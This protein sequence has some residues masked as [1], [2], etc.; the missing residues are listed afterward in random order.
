M[1]IGKVSNAIT[2]EE[3]AKVADLPTPPICYLEIPKLAVEPG[4][5]TEGEVYYNT[6][7][8]KFY[9]YENAAWVE[10]LFSMEKVTP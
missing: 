10:V 8:E 2:A 3:R 1:K 7:N 9:L 5:G 6:T 4:T